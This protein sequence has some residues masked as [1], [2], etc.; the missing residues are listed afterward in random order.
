MIVR[1]GSGSGQ[2]DEKKFCVV[3]SQRDENHDPA[4]N[5]R[6]S[7]SDASVDSPS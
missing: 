4:L 7:E 2:G 1:R 5:R 6:G 3:V